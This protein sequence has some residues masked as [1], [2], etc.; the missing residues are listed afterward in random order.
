MNEQRF[1][2]APAAT[3]APGRRPGERPRGA[4]QRAGC[5]LLTSDTSHADLVALIAAA[6]GAE[7]TVHTEA[8]TLPAVAPGGVLLVAAD[9]LDA[10]DGAADA[11]GNGAWGGT[12][13]GLGAAGGMILTGTA[14]D[15]DRLW[16]AAAVH[17]GARVAILPEASAW[18][19]EYLGA[20]A[21]TGGEGRVSVFLGASGGAG[22][23]TAAALTAVAAARAGYSA[24]LVD[25]DA[26][27]A[28]LWPVL[29]PGSAEGLS[30]EDTVDSHGRIPP[31]QL[32]EMLPAVDGLRIMT[33]LDGLSAFPAGPLQQGQRPGNRPGSVLREVL[34]AAARAFQVV[35]VDGGRGIPPQAAELAH[36]TFHAIPA[37]RAARLGL[38]GGRLAAAG[39]LAYA[40]VTGPLPTGADSPSIARHAGI[41]LAG[42]LPRMASVRR[43]GTE[44]RLLRAAAR[45]AVARRI[46]PLLVLCV[47]PADGVQ[48]PAQASPPPADEHRVEAEPVTART[49]GQGA[50]R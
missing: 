40:V 26:A 8:S 12:A 15:Q 33:S 22:T 21:T 4:P 11:T 10:F 41:P 35:V 18:L 13:G 17:P 46:E 3:A 39:G 27:G 43:A 50:A 14:G 23:T 2:A 37:A 49:A 5:H 20:L 28:G 24:V 34:A 9:G 38:S 48:P 44:G 29:G 25:A 16:R 42:H 36:A 31:Q 47:P 6:A 30:W 32:L 45:R 7:L 19:G 1:V